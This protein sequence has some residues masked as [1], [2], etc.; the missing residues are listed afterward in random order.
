MSAISGKYMRGMSA[1]MAARLIYGAGVAKKLARD[2]GI[3]VITAKIWLANGVPAARR[4]EMGQILLAE[5][6]RRNA[7]ID[8]LLQEVDNAG[9]AQPHEVARARL[10]ARNRSPAGPSGSVGE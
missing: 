9:E 2:M 1:A 7:E 6:E 5:F 10:R 8:R 3:A 4:A